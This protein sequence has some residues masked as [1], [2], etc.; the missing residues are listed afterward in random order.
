MSGWATVL[1]GIVPQGCGGGRYAESSGERQEKAEKRKTKI[2]KKR[3]TY[4]LRYSKIDDG[5]N[6][7]A[8]PGPI[9]HIRDGHATIMSDATTFDFS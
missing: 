5:I 2:R 7:S 3:L 1:R 8:S 9:E 6:S 4:W